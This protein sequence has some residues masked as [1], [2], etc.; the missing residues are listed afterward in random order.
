VNVARLAEP[1]GALAYGGGHLWASIPDVDSVSRIDP[2]R[3]RV[4]T[5][6]VGRRPAGLALAHDRLF[7]A[8]NTRHTVAVL[9][10]G[11]PQRRAIQQLRVPP[12]PYAMTAGGG[13][14]WVTGMANGTVTRIVP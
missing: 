10:P 3:S 7:V 5:T 4:V 2:R 12:N 1:A 14:V 13:H 6:A 9:D 8:S 11:A